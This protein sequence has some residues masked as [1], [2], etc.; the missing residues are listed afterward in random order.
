M[1]KQTVIKDGVFKGNLDWHIWREQF[2][3]DRRAPVAVAGATAQLA[4]FG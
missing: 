1:N 3:N 2:P 4:M